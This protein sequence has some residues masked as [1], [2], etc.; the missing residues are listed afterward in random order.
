MIQVF[1]KITRNAIPDVKAGQENIEYE[2]MGSEIPF[3]FFFSLLHKHK[4][5]KKHIK[6]AIAFSAWWDSRSFHEDL[7]NQDKIPASGI[8]IL[9]PCL[10]NAEG[11]W[12]SI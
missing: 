7:R 8:I 2:N 12:H 1:Y 3:F 10:V 6:M 9:I 11:L 4:K 5:K